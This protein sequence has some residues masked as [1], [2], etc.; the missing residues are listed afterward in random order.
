MKPGDASSL[1]AYVKQQAPA[2]GLDWKAVMSVAAVEGLSGAIGDN[3]TS[4]G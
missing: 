4:Y 1:E 3:G 2:Y